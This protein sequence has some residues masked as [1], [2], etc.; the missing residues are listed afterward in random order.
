LVEP[1]GNAKAAWHKSQRYIYDAKRAARRG[2]VLADGLLLVPWAEGKDGVL[3]VY[4][5]EAML[6]IKTTSATSQVV[7]CPSDNC[8]DPFTA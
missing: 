4:W 3:D 7:A 8:H 6:G 5:R 2:L 1:K